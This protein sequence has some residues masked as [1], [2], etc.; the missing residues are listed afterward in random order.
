MKQLSLTETGFLPK[1]GKVTRK[2]EFLAEMTMVVPWSRLEVLTESV[3][4]KAGR[5]RRPTS[6]SVMLRIHLLQHWFGYSDPAMEE[7]LHDDIPLLRQLAGL[8]AFED[9]IRAIQRS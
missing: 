2:A 3:Y 9:A 1:R 4:P 6:L 5:G 8:G 7:A